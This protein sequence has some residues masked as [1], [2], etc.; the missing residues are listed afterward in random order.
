MNVKYLLILVLCVIATAA[1]TLKFGPPLLT[2]ARVEAPA[3]PEPLTSAQGDAILK[4]LAAIRGTLEKIEKQGD[5]NTRRPAAQAQLPPTASVSI[6]NRPVFGNADAKVTV[7][8]FT[9]Y[10]CP[11]CRRFMQTTYPRL[12]K[13]YIDTGKVRWVVRD[14][15]LGFHKQ[16]RIAATAANCA[17]EQGR[18]WEYRER[19]FQNQSQLLPENLE[20]YAKQAGIDAAAFSTCLNSDRFEAMFEKDA[21]AAASER[22]TGTPT[23]VIGTLR[24]NQTVIG[25][26]VVGAQ[27]YPVFQGEID[28]LLNA[29]NPG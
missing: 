18:Y 6:E 17:G 1:A 7:V 23:F 19:L 5:A 11:Y 10:Q 25:K 26:R 13:D 8:E 2:N 24:K 15:P 27:P 3:Q 12:K 22:I 29:T 16:A 28:R 14:L 21:Q 20:Q 9:D 4:E